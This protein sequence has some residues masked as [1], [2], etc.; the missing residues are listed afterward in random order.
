MS[1]RKY[2]PSLS[3]LKKLHLEELESVKERHKRNEEF[4]KIANDI[5]YTSGSIKLLEEHVSLQFHLLTVAG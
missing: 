3:A 1:I 5:K 2:C 4:D